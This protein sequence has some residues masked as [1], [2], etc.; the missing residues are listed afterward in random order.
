MEISSLALLGKMDISNIRNDSSARQVDRLFALKKLASSG[1][2][3]E[4]IRSVLVAHVLHTAVEYVEVI[5]SV[6]PISAIIAVPYSADGDAVAALRQKGF[7]VVVPNDV[8]D[9]YV[10]AFEESKKALEETDRPLIIQEVG[11][12][13]SKVTDELTT[14]PNFLGIVEDTNNGHWRYEQNGPHK[15]PIL[16]MAQSPLK[17]VEDT[18]I[19]D[20]VVYSVERILRDE[21]ASIMQGARCGVIGYGKIGTSNAFALKGR[22]AVVSVYDI[23]PAKNMR[24]KVEGF[25]PKPL[26][27]MLPEADLIIGA[28]G[29]TSIR[30]DDMPHIKNGAI[31]ASASSKRLEFALDDFAKECVVEEVS[32][33]ITKYTQ[34][35]DSIFY[36]LNDGKPV[37]FRDNSILGTILD[38]IYSELF[39]CMREVANKNFPAGLHH[40]PPAVQ[41]E[42]AKAW[43]ME[44]DANFKKYSDEKVWTYPE[45]LDLGRP[46]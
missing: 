43:L 9:T 26:H 4:G 23:D 5:N 34:R 11:G 1:P 15:C 44:H 33:L 2:N 7:N 6:F 45:S 20:A 25:F 30:L 31:L 18:I 41:N 36:V 38:M 35:N 39:V 27:D 8:P 19:G 29:Q 28:T 32:S 3:P 12:Y 42:V 24:A 14:Y 16:S 22:E 17:D 40:S 21:F 13:L 10:K 46:T 37:N